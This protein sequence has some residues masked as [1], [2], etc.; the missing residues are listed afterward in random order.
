MESVTYNIQHGILFLCLALESKLVSQFCE[1]EN[2]ALIYNRITN[3][4]GNGHATSVNG[5]NGYNV[6]GNNGY[7]NNHNQESETV[8]KNQVI[9]PESYGRGRGDT[10]TLPINSGPAPTQVHFFTT[11]RGKEIQASQQLHAPI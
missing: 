9:T 7:W 5:Q 11:V 8:D 4:Y 10:F 1:D 2:G 3:G 6:Y